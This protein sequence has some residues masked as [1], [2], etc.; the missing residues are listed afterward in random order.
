MIAF[1]AKDLLKEIEIE[2]LEHRPGAARA[3]DQMGFQEALPDG[4]GGAR[5]WEAP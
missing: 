4:S 2:L 3:Q 1:T 5:G